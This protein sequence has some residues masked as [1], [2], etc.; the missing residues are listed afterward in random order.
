MEARP[1]HLWLSTI[2]HSM[3]LSLKGGSAKGSPFE[4][5][6]APNLAQNLARPPS[7]SHIHPL[8]PKAIRAAVL[9]HRSIRGQPAIVLGH[10]RVPPP[11]ASQW[12]P[13]GRRCKIGRDS[14]LVLDLMYVP[15]PTEHALLHSGHASA[16]PMHRRPASGRHT[17][18]ACSVQLAAC[19]RGRL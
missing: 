8:G 5:G 17:L 1:A 7:S 4:A 2:C 15:L 11:Q 3:L 16:G 10:R 9:A 14:L 19:F 13:S 18:A 6:E 12:S